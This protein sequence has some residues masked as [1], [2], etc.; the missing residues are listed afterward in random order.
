MDGATPMS[1]T[2]GVYIRVAKTGQDVTRELIVDGLK[3]KELT[4]PQI[5]SIIQQFA[6]SLRDY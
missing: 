5:I 1:E 2:A 6:S 3:L 4:K